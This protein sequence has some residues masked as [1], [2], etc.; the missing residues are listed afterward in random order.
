MS[1]IIVSE[2]LEKMQQAKKDLIKRMPKPTHILKWGDSK[3]PLHLN[4]DCIVV[5]GDR[6][7]PA[8]LTTIK[9]L[10]NDNSRTRSK[11]QK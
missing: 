2:F 1:K 5:I 6:R 8:K 3:I 10:K 4:K 7:I 11:I 9:K